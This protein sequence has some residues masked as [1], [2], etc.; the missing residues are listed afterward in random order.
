MTALR[1][2]EQPPPTSGVSRSV[3]GRRR[4]R[5][6]AK[7]GLHAGLLD[8]ADA[9]HQLSHCLRVGLHEALELRRVLV[10]EGRARRSQ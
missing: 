10:H 3:I 1:F 4:V 2:F 9:S 6:V 7:D 8:A 5:A